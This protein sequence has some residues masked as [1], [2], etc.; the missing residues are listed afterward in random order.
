MYID[1]DLFSNIA[2]SS[3]TTIPVILALIQV[4]KMTRLIPDR[5]APIASIGLGILVAFLIPGPELITLG[6]KILTG[7]LLGLSASGL[8]SG[9]KTTSDAIRMDRANERLNRD[10]HK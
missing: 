9:V 7:I 4:L 5:Y 6:S 2:V 8:Y 10:R 1:N 3:A